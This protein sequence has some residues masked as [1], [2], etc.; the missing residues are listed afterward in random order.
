M[1]YYPLN[2]FRDYIEHSSKGQ[3]WKKHKYLYIDSNGR[4]VYS[5]DAPK[6][7]GNHGGGKSTMTSKKSYSYGL[8][9]DGSIGYVDVNRDDSYG[10]SSRKFNQS[11]AQ[12]VRKAVKTAKK[13]KSDPK[14]Y[15]KDLLIS[16]LSEE[17]E[18]RIKKGVKSSYDTYSI[19]ERA[20][21]KNAKTKSKLKNI[22]RLSPTLRS[23][24]GISDSL[25][26]LKKSKKKLHGRSHAKSAR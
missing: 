26:K 18:K 6:T 7:S 15:G 5:K 19:N 20:K 9:D 17:K 11:P 13:I 24:M 23:A 1:K 2:D 22:A 14:S 12:R 16:K 8:W 10:G 4:Y 25:N 3:K 21:A